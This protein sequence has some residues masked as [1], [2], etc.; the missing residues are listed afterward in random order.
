MEPVLAPDLVPIFADGNGIQQVLLNLVFN[1]ADALQQDGGVIKVTTE[2]QRPPQGGDGAGRVRVRVTDNGVGIPP[3]NLER[4]FEP[5]FTTKP[6][7]AGAGLGL[8]LCQ[9]IILNNHGT[10][11][12]ES[13]IGKGT[14]V[15]ICLP[16]HVDANKS[17]AAASLQ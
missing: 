5:F 2:Y 12:V 8:S 3:D 6:A 11:G 4:V 7:G 1:A 14:T 15:T 9:R 13:A 10:I 16:A 17:A